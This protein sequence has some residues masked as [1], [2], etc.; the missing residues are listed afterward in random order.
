MSAAQPGSPAPDSHDLVRPD[1]GV[2]EPR[3]LTVRELVERSAETMALRWVGGFR[4]ADRPAATPAPDTVDQVG[5]LNL[6]HPHRIQV[7]GI[8]EV[9]YFHRLSDTRRQHIVDEIIAGE[10]PALVMSEGILPPP[11][12]VAACD[13]HGL[14]LLECVLPSARAIELLRSLLAKALAVSCSMHGVLMDVLGLGVMITGESG[15]GKSE[16]GLELVSRGHGLVADD[17]V[18]LHRIGP[19][20][21]EGRCPPML[22][23]LL[24]V[25]GLG[26]LD[27][28][29]VFGET[30][31]RRKMRLKL[32][33][34]L[35]RRSTH[36]DEYERLPLEDLNQEVLGMQVRKVIVPVAA[37]R[38]IA[39]LTEAAVRNTILRL[40][41]IDTMREF[42]ARQQRAIHASES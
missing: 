13:A 3:T 37:G 42:I 25:R 17:V 12:L 26:L 20:T 11:A 28:K 14:P 32:I 2:Q 8:A 1:E 27:I 30:A 22:Q 6:I 19:R 36:E 15:L 4:G 21:I 35:V 33:V 29:T 38:N 5:Y 18:E 10:P 16:L 41:G 34:H 7:L 23:G 24:E 9:A 39:V 40:R 31:V